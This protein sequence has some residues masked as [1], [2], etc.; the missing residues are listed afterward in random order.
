YQSRAVN[1]DE[2]PIP[3]LRTSESA[4]AGAAPLSTPYGVPESVEL[5]V[6][7]LAATR[8]VP[9]D[10][11]ALARGRAQQTRSLASALVEEGVAS[12]EGIARMLAA[13]HHLPLVDLALVGVDDVAASEV[14]LHV[15]ERI[16]AIPYAFE[17]GVLRVAVADPSNVHGL[18]ELR[19]ATRHPLELGVAS[20]D[21][22]V[23]AIRKLARATEAFGARAAVDGEAELLVE[24]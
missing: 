6:D 1:D 4:Q 10:K 15:L 24:V 13:R 3:S 18:D 14:A 22:I 5:V 7:L 20:R 16:G 2:K 23:G 17:D 21:D 19:L 12:S 9:E 11:L 8:L